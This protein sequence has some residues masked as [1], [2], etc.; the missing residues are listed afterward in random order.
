M[1]DT[2]PKTEQTD[3]LLSSHNYDGIQEY[4]NPTPGWWN[5]LFIGTIVF[6]PVYVLWFHSPVRENNLQTQ[7]QTAM[8]EN[9]KLQF[10]DLKLEPTG[11]N[12]LKY[13]NDEKWLDF[14]KTTFATHCVQCHGREGEGVSAPNLTDDSYKN[15]KTIADIPKVVSEGANNGAMP[16]WTK[17]HPNE[18]VFVSA[19][20]ASL[21]GK[22]LP[23]TRGVEGDEIDPWPEPP[24]REPSETKP[25][26][27]VSG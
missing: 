8:A 12:V 9:L 26:A 27:E 1:S 2:L 18:I 25:E 20:V 5:W 22:N 17:L 21:R 10:G 3:E 23:S 7:F 6:A 15:V 16:A 13:L 24:P 11:D 14:G 19:Y 4:D